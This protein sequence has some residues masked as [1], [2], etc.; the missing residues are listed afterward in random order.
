MLPLA[1]RNLTLQPPLVL[2]P[3]SGV[4]NSA[5]RR[6]V[7]E[8]NPGAV[9][10]VISEFLSVEGM[11]RGSQRTK[12]MMR[13]RP[14]ERP[15]GI[16]IFGYDI[17]RMRDAAMMVQDSGADVV[18][19][20][21]GC[22]A[23]KV[24]RRGGG[25]ELM[26]QPEHLQKI[27]AAVRKAVSIPLTLKMRSGW[28]ETSRNCIEISRMCESEGIEMLTIHGRTRAQLYRGIADWSVVGDAARA[29]SIPVCGSGDVTDAASAQERLAA[30]AAGLYIGRAAI[31]NPRVF[32]QIVAPDTTPLTDS[33]TAA[34]ILLRYRE[35][36]L[37]DMPAT[38][39]LGKVKQM[40]SQMG[41][42]NLWR[43]VVLRAMKDEDVVSI[44]CAAAQGEFA[45]WEREHAPEVPLD[46]SSLSIGGS[47]AGASES[48]S[49]E[50]LVSCDAYEPAQ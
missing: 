6:L 10:Y 4:T 36:M 43:K 49:A 30:G 16:Q 25:A 38:A 17:E 33:M 44:L 13:F 40:A 24:V 11:T 45:R 22:P 7:K 20:N 34:K 47:D 15:F 9:G 14:E 28:D 21:C 19:I 31:G 5:F 42:G 46:G 50:C 26:R 39:A 35:L 41:K 37:E 1:L 27:I 2:A 23:P 29:V 32:S 12:Q 48:E 3:M 8:L 18:D